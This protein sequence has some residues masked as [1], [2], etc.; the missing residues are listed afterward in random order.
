[1]TYDQWK[2]RDPNEPFAEHEEEKM[3]MPDESIALE[4]CPFCGGQPTFA[5]IEPHSH[6]GGIAAFM[7]DYA[8][9]AYIECG[10][11]AGLIDETAHAVGARWNTR[12][13]PAPQLA[14]LA[15]NCAKIAEGH[16]VPEDA[17]LRMHR[18]EGYNEACHDIAKAI[19]DAH[20]VDVDAATG[21]ADDQDFR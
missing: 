8:G 7:P 21:T 9:S 18:D 15:E 20:G 14:D 11:G 12:A 13:L 2:T 6:K 19:R 5:A 16:I 3:P 1:M 10:C 17:E 4:P